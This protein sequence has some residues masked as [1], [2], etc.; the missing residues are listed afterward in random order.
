MADR[1]AYLY[2]QQ[3]HP[4]DS[5]CLRFLEPLEIVVAEPETGCVTLLD[6]EGEPQCVGRAE[7]D[8][9]L[10]SGSD[11]SLRLMLA[12]ELGPYCRLRRVGD[13]SIM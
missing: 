12:K 3:A 1:F 9:R 5:D 13:I 6:A 11:V 8:R 2:E 7:F 10:A 4:V